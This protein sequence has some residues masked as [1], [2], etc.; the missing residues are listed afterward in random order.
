MFLNVVKM[1]KADTYVPEGSIH[2]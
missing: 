2:C 1:V